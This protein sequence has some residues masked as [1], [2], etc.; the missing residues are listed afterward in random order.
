MTKKT[1][2]TDITSK[3]V[4][5]R[6]W[7]QSAFLLIWL[8]PMGF[9]LHGVCGPVFHC[10]SCPLASFACPI[11][12]LANFSS[13]HLFPFVAVGIV[14][15]F[16]VFFGSLL[17][18]WA[19]P[20][21]L[22]QD[23]AAKAPIPKFNLPQWTGY[24]RYVVLIAAVL[25][26]PFF[27]GADHPLFICRLCPVGALEAAVP[28][29]VQQAM[30]GQQIVW[31]NALKI[32]ILILVVAAMFLSYRPWC[33]VLC[34]LGAILGM[35]NRASVFFLRLDGDKCNNCKKC[36]NLCEYGI[37]PSK[38]PNSAA[39]IRCLE[40]TTCPTDALS[41]GS[42]FEKG[43]KTSDSVNSESLTAQT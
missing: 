11:G 28:N 19:C 27:A 16:A 20:F 40:C 25:A 42:I 5:L 1:L 15:L 43:N 7:V 24:F 17:C 34:P 23:L 37:E 8:D 4:P 29:V 13:L 26:I 21:G 22:L 2:I 30:T 18:G 38:N 6:I 32:T 41:L 12:V 3:L 35:F 36:H 14:V 33:R 31:P 10:Y 39:C 9:R